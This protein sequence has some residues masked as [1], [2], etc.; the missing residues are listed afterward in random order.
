L[1]FGG[2]RTSHRMVCAIEDAGFQ[3]RTSVAWLFGSGF[4]KNLN[5][6]KKVDEIQG[7][8]RDVVGKKELWGHNAG[9]GAG[10]FS[11]N[12]YEG[13]T[14]IRRSE[15]MT[16]GNSK[17]EGWGTALKPGFEI[18][19]LAR[20]PLSEKTVATNVLKWGTGA[21][22]I[23]K[24]R[25]K[26]PEPHH[27]YGRTSGE[28]SFVGKGDVSVT[29]EE[30]RWPSNVIMECT[31]KHPI[32]GG[33]SEV[34][35][36][37]E[38]KGGIFS[39]SQ[40]KPAGPTYKDK[41]MVHTDPNCPCYQLD[42]QS[43]T[44]KSGDGCI[45]QREGYFGEHGGLGKKGDVQ[46]TYGDE[47]G[48]SRFFYCAK[49]SKWERNVG[50]EDINPVKRDESRKEGNPGGDNPRNRG[51]HKVNNHHPTVK[52]I[53]LMEYLV[54]LI[55]PL[56]GIVL[57]PF[58]GSGTTLIACERNAFQYIGIEKEEE[59]HKIATARLEYWRQFKNK[60]LDLL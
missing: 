45:R 16:V 21:L 10:S 30:G 42:K 18:I 48:A 20:K 38:S 27:N 14:G 43:G 23:D 41:P 58:A 19:C 15:P 29:P 54:N 25:I 46:T 6:G 40:G 11:K 56:G 4:P 36:P 5:V 9:S 33:K 12:K 57:D 17:W 49:T 55:T 3:I 1:S 47:G 60:Q 37:E 52:P 28:K 24:S 13:Q 59:Y 31:C 2:D 51:V 39:P 22:N 26:G 7:N 8:K 50:C 53:A 35:P 44:L 34:I 32:P